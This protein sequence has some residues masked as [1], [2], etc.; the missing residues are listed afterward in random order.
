MPSKE[1]KELRQS[2]ELEQALAM[3]QNELDA[4]PE[5]IWGKRNISW[6]YYEY[7][8]RYAQ[9]INFDGFIENLQKIKELNLPETEVMIFDTAAYQIGSMLFKIQN[10]EPID[11][12]RVNQI[13]DIVKE[14][15][16]TKPSESYSLLMKAF[17]KGSQ[18]WSRFIEFTDWWGLENFRQEDYNQEEYNNRQMPALAD[19]VYGSYCKKLI[20]GEAIKSFGTLRE[21]DKDKIKSFLPQLDVIIDK[22]PEYRFLSYYKAQMLLETGSKEN[23]LASFLPF[24]KQKKNDFWVWGL[25]AEIFKEDKELEFACYCKALSLKSPNEFLIKTRYLFSELLVERELFSEAKA[26]IKNIVSVRQAKG[27]KIPNNILQ[28]TESSWYKKAEDISN[29]KDLYEKHRKKA[30]ELLYKDLPEYIVAI[31]FVNN[32]KKILTFIK[33]KKMNGFFNYD[34]FVK[35]PLI[36]DIIKVRIEPVGKDGFHRLLT[37]ESIEDISEIEL[38]KSIKEVSGI[39]RIPEGKDFGFVTDVFVTTDFI[40][41]NKIIDKQELSLKAILSFDKRKND[42]GWK[43]YQIN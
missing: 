33:D 29:N 9:E 28:C 14:C 8:K 16:F 12:A 19:K 15:H 18:N 10:S 25:M 6:V 36:G 41:K 24:A 1:I 21:V 30:E 7:L 3:A 4:A 32:N 2:G 26:E 5:N 22:Y 38:P 27:W 35:N 23:A 13:F 11:Y 20:D 43:C 39:I 17:Q 40:K 42:W 37:L 34:G 31:E